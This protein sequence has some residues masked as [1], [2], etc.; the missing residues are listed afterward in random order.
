MLRNA[1]KAVSSGQ[2]QKRQAA[3]GALIILLC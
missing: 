1:G 3:E 2:G